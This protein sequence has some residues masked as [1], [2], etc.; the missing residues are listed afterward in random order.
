MNS[1]EPFPSQ[2]SFCLRAPNNIDCSQLEGRRSLLCR[3]EYYK[4]LNPNT[5]CDKR[6]EEC[7]NLY[8]YKTALKSADLETKETQR[9]D[10][11]SPL[12]Y[13]PFPGK[14][15]PKHKELKKRVTP[16]ETGS[17]FSL[18]PETSETEVEEEEVEHKDSVTVTENDL[19]GELLVARGTTKLPYELSESG[20]QK[21]NAVPTVAED[22]D[23]SK[24]TC[25]PKRDFQCRYRVFG[26]KRNQVKTM[27][28]N[29]SNYKITVINIA[30]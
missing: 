29:I 19:L 6:S 22:S 23:N 15:K 5:P 4:R 30:F 12:C 21:V 18:L 27:Y 3:K 24:P 14:R 26:G 7:E 1:F 8:T 17:R 10:L 13:V 16:D 9:C 2:D 20:E 11:K 25:D 28:G